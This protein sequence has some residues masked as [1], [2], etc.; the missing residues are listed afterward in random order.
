MNRLAGKNAVITGAAAGV[1]RAASLLFARE[2]AAVA[3][4]DAHAAMGEETAAM[5]RAEGGDALFVKANLSDPAEIEQ[6]AK[7]CMQWRAVIDVLFNNGTLA[8]PIDF[9]H[10]TLDNWNQQL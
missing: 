3:C 6:M 5:I 10:T 2:G 9:E 4:V 7:V 1:G 8:E